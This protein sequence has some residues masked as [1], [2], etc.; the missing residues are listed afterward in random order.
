M[1]ISNLFNISTSALFASQMA[2]NVTSNNIANANTPGFTRQEAVLEPAGAAKVGGGYVG[3]GVNV[4]AIK[5]DYDSFIQSQIFTQQQNY[6]GSSAAS[7][8]MSQ[9][10]QVFNDANG[11]GLSS[12]LTD[13]T[14]AW[15]TVSQDPSNQSSRNVLMQKAD[16]LVSQ[17]QNKQNTIIQILNNTDENINGLV[18]EAN[19]I[20]SKIAGLNQQISSLESGSQ[21]GQAN[22]LLDQRDQLM[23][24]LSQYIGYNYY[25]DSTGQVNI[26]SGMRNLVSGSTAN[27]LTAEKDQ[28][29]LFQLHL[30]GINVTSNIKGGQL[31][32][33]I[34]ARSDVQNQT[35][36]P[37]RKLTASITK[38]VNLLHE[39]GYGLDGS[40][41]NDFFNPLTLTV[42]NYSA[43]ASATASVS[44][45]AA[46]NLDEYNITFDASNNYYVYDTRTN[47]LVT[48]GAYTSGNPISFD[49]IQITITGPVTKADSF[50]VS[51]L[52]DA[53]DNFGVA[54]TD[55]DKI[56]AASSGS[57][58]P[59][60]NSN[61]V[62]ISNL[63]SSGAVSGLGG[64]TLPDFYNGIVSA[65]GTLSKSAQDNETF[66]DSLL[67]QL[68]QQRDSVSG[69]SI[70]E[71]AANLIMYQR[72]YQAGAKMI[73]VT[74]E[75]MQTLL[76]M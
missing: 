73:Q 65:A 51:P 61:A 15:N 63:L 33:L 18:G 16:A 48:S 38:E 12:Y 9:L 47:S 64:A 68:N 1:S 50:T 11:T 53:I 57:S 35:L 56:A 74:D 59:G 60:D 72:A 10:E 43:G 55:P 39:S 6:S 29:G 34:A 37:L 31:G 71:E 2:L 66:N 62:N 30:D 21:T 8:V 49:G 76:Q 70:D 4:T 58:L 23:S 17:V 46:L 27:Q 3:R 28:N 42:N 75:L 45:L 24:Q 14:N 22:D 19:S 5:R 25:E 69:V 20:A 7:T 13:F 54:V 36:T 26:I 40:T 67:N 44:N 32:G 52:T 41:G